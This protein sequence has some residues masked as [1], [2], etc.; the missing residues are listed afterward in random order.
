MAL[1]DS[2]GGELL[3][4]KANLNVFRQIWIE[5]YSSIKRLRRSR[6]FVPNQS[7]IEKTVL[8]LASVPI[9]SSVLVYEIV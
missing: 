7:L 1:A 2:C 9:Q 4:E 3:F 8:W 6:R 5:G